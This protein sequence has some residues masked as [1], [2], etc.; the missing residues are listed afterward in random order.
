MLG[1]SSSLSK[2]GEELAGLLLTTLNQLSLDAQE[3]NGSDIHQLLHHTVSNI[4][5]TV[6]SGSFS[7]G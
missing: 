6:Y 2:T 7:Y 4:I 1:G 5:I 3:L